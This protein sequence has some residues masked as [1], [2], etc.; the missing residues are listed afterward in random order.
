MHVQN[1]HKIHHT[2]R[3]LWSSGP[4][5]KIIKTCKSHTNCH[6]P[7]C[8]QEWFNICHTRHIALSDNSCHPV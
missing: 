3:T 7:E 6:K 2:Y 4:N 8:C 5:T 1:I